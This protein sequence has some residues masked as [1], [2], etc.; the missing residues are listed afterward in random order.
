MPTPVEASSV[1]REIGTQEGTRPYRSGRGRRSTVL[2][3]H[4]ALGTSVQGQ[5]GVA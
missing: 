5:D 4:I 3:E 2:C 1:T